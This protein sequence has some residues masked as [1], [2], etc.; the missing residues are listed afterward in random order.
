VSE[1]TA[2][3]AF[4]GSPARLAIVHLI[5]G[6]V[7]VAVFLMTG[8]FMR[9]GYPGVAPPDLAHRV[10]FRTHHLYLLAAALVHLLVGGQRRTAGGPVPRPRLGIASSTLLLAA[11]PL[12]LLGFATEHLT[13]A[14]RGEATSL[15]WYTLAAGVLLHLLAWRWGTAA[16]A[17]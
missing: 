3:L 6:W 4:R 8:V 2:P 9:V 12:L 10:F 7:T 17:E 16:P 5:V 1:G 15:G 11:P 14:L 13:P